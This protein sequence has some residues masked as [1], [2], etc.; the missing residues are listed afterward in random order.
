MQGC[1]Q[2]ALARYCT[3]LLFQEKKKRTRLSRAHEEFLAAAFSSF[4]ACGTNDR[5]NWMALR[6]FLKRK[7]APASEEVRD[8]T[9]EPGEKRS[10]SAGE[11]STVQEGST[12]VEEQ[13]LCSAAK[14]VSGRKSSTELVSHYKEEWE[15]EFTWLIPKMDSGK[16]TGMLCRL[17]LKHKCTGKYNHS[18]VWTITPCVCIRKDSLYANLY[19]RITFTRIWF[20]IIRY[21]NVKT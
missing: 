13:D 19:G 15:K 20:W 18:T 6:R 12:G 17:C 8:S 5:S 14:P 11:C 21:F 3:A 16:F 4:L 9:E 1:P 7:P 10:R 2:S